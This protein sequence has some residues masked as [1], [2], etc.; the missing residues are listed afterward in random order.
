MKLYYHK[1][2]IIL[3]LNNAFNYAYTSLERNL[4][5]IRNFSTSVMWELKKNRVLYHF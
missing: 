3:S 2:N 4:G 5:K 1:L